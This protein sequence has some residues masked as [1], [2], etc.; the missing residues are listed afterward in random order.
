[1]G[2]HACLADNNPTTVLLERAENQLAKIHLQLTY[3]KDTLTCLKKALVAEHTTGGT[4][5]SWQVE[6][7]GR[8][9]TGPRRPLKALL[10]IST[11]AYYDACAC[12]LVSD[13]TG[14]QAP[15]RPVACWASAGHMIWCHKLHRRSHSSGAQAPGTV[16]ACRCQGPVESNGRIAVGHNPPAPCAQPAQ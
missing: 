7:S 11:G 10:M 14:Q 12:V 9:S 16:T 4:C 13:T 2:T 1:M 15:L 6:P 3:L 8:L 5:K